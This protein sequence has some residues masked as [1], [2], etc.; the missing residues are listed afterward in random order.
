[1]TPTIERELN[2]TLTEEESRSWF[3]DVVPAPPALGVVIPV[4][5]GRDDNLRLVLK[6][7]EPQLEQLVGVVVVE[8]GMA[9]Q[10]DFVSPFPVARV[11]TPKHKP[12]LEQPRNV[13][14][15]HLAARSEATHVWFLDS[16]VIV[17][18]D[19]AVQLMSAIQASLEPRIV[20]A[21]YEWLP[22]GSRGPDPLVFNDARWAMFRRYGPQDTL[23]GDL[24]AGLACWSGNLVW[25]IA[26]FE[27][28]GGF[29][30]ELH[31]GRCEDGE[32]GLRAVSM[33]V[34]ITFAPAARGWH[35][36]HEINLPLILERNRRDVPLINKR[37]P[38]VQG[39]DLFV[40]D[41]DGKRFEVKCGVCGEMVNTGAWWAHAEGCGELEL[42]P[43]RRPSERRRPERP[44]RPPRS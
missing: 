33:G 27:R 13:G 39:A 24:S 23:A 3:P 2:M 19:C 38:W 35:L 15:R 29:W 22:A 8:D 41:R 28:V 18:P 12:G 43:R 20:V 17:G 1:M 16:D 25:P 37:H 21:P 42:R 11:Q 40:V 7:L 4:G 6:A 34:G 26:E 14:V 10:P 32:L 31:H 9:L 44:S 36:W 30:N 5:P